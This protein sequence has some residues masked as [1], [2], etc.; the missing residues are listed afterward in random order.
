M[1]ESGG[2]IGGKHEVFADEEGVEA[3]SAE[4][5]EI[6]VGAE[7]G[8]GDSEAVVGDVLDEFV[9]PFYADRESFQVAVVDTNN[10]GACG[11][12]AVEFR[13]RVHFDERLH[14]E[15]AAKCDEVAQ[16][17]VGEGSDDEEEAVCIVGASFPDLP[18]IEDEI[19][20][21]GWECDFF[22]GIAKIFQGAAEKLAFGKDRER[23]GTR[24]LE[25]FGE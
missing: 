14:M 3:S 9:G 6:G 8:L 11:Q 7:T 2:R 10:A 17:W 5:A 1:E 15:F 23:S 13:A 4:I 21:E 16:E 12:S 24:R 20:A 18:G 25:R 22:A 19:L